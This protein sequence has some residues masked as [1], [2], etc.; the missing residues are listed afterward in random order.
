[1]LV[2]GRRFD[3]MGAN[4]AEDEALSQGDGRARIPG[5]S[6]RRKGRRC[7]LR[8]PRRRLANWGRRAFGA[9]LIERACT[10]ELE[11]EVELDYA[12]DGLR[13]EM[14]FPLASSC[15]AGTGKDSA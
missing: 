8:W 13:C 12:S 4:A 9:H 2:K 15:Q 10:C 11:A 6:R 1:M 5:R 7:R 3:E 14:V